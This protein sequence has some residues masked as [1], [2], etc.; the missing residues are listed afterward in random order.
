MQLTRIA[1]FSTALF[2]ST[3]AAFH[4]ARAEEKPPLRFENGDAVALIGLDRR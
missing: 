2:V 3:W 1:Q 4:S